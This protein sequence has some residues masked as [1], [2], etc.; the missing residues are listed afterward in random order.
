[1]QVIAERKTLSQALVDARKNATYHQAGHPGF[2]H[3]SV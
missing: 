1:M 2:G 3:I